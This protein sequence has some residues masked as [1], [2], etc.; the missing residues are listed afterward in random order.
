MK[1]NSCED[2]ING[3]K[4][5]ILIPCYNE[6]L[7]IQNVI[8]DFKTVLPKADIYVFDNNSTDQTANIAKAA[9]AIVGRE[10]RQGKGHV[11]RQMFERIDADIYLMIDG[12]NTYPARHALDVLRPIVVGEADMSVGDRLS[13]KSYQ[14]A[15]RRGTLGSW[16]N[17]LFTRSVNLLFGG[18]IKDVFSGYRAFSRKFVKTVPILSTGFQVEAEMTLFALDKGLSIVE[19]PITFQER[20][21]GS[22]SKLNTFHDGFRILLK[23]LNICKNYRPFL[24]YGIIASLFILMSLALGIPIILEYFETGLVPR[25]PTAILS[26]ALMVMGMICLT[27]GLILNT[28]IEHS[29]AAYEL[30]FKKFS[31]QIVE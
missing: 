3:M 11:V 4:I 9:G 16:G 12:D 24:F 5:A 8:E 14:G 19:V 10:F 6:A 29:R 26:S 22:E 31:T 1:K 25:F 28:V 27:I 18:T 21:E 2:S 30:Q 23:I 17:M 13:N 15:A 7:T 20:P